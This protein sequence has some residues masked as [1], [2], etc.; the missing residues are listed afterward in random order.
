MPLYR[1]M[2]KSFAKMEK[3]LSP[4]ELQ[5]FLGCPFAQLEQYHFG[6]GTWV[7]TCLLEETQPLYQY[8]VQSGVLQKDDMSALLL[9]AF[10]MHL[11][12]KRCG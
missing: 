3:H 12:A 2:Q 10:Y 1:E 7:R 4:C 11:H 8:F 9:R 5:L 6:L